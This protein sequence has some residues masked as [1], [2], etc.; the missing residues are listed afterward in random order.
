MSLAVFKKFSE[1]IIHL[2]PPYFLTH[3]LHSGAIAGT[4]TQV[5]VKV[6]WN[7]PPYRESI[8]RVDVGDEVESES[9]VTTVTDY[10]SDVVD[11]GIA[12]EIRRCC[13]NGHGDYLIFDVDGK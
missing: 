6:A 5:L 11:E 3:P 7:A 1:P 8:E 2:T 13:D 10:P 12:G 4:V 9:V